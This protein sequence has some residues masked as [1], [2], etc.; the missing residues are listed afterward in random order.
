M[1]IQARRRNQVSPGSDAIIR[2]QETI[3]RIGTT[4]TQGVLKERGASGWVLRNTNTP[5]QTRTKANSVPILVISPTTRA[6][7]NAANKLTNKQKSKLDFHGVLNFLCTAEK[8]GGKNPSFDMEKNTRD[9][10]SNIT[11][12]TEE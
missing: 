9:C 5:K 11:M 6:G 1:A 10:P 3:P 12:I 4:G 8:T 2:K 7:T